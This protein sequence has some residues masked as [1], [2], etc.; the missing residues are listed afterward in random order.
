MIR[1]Q[2]HALTLN[3]GERRLCH[4]LSVEFRAGENWAILGANGS[5]KTTLLHALAG[6][7][8]C[9][10]GHVL[11]DGREINK[12]PARERAREVG[13][14]LQDYAS[15]FP[16]NALET[17]LTGRHPHLSRWAMEGDDDRN[18]A[19]QAL[20]AVGLA[21]FEQRLLTTLS[22]G[23]R[24]RVEIAAV[25]A[26]NPSIGLWDEPSNH[27]DLRHQGEILRL[28]AARTEQPRHLN[29]FVLHD[30]NAAQRLCSHALLLFPDGTA[31]AGPIS[32]ALTRTALERVYSCTFEE[33]HYESRRYYTSR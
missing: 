27:L 25:L 10:H 31:Q 14:L 18:L 7:H 32:G 16:A 28:L 12:W 11:L 17:V 20:T 8:P 6:L 9:T 30:I 23:E 22:G 2:T 29:L 24:R 26:Q 21:S 13:L 3:V 1:L 5:G 19:R 4:D 33:I 15:A